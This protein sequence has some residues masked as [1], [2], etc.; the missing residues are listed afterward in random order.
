M[1]AEDFD[2]HCKKIVTKFLENYQSKK[3]SL[4]HECLK[5]AH[6]ERPQFFC[7]QSGNDG[8]GDLF[9]KWHIHNHFVLI[10]G[11]KVKVNQKEAEIDQFLDE[12]MPKYV[13]YFLY[14]FL[15]VYLH[16]SF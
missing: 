1:T 14:I 9:V 12:F 16:L 11:S 5:L 7:G 2:K 6:E 13:E 4:H 8:D 3:K 10:A 15:I